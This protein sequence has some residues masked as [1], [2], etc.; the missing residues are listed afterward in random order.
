MEEEA[1]FADGT[2]SVRLRLQASKVVDNKDEML[3]A[4]AKR[5][6]L[7]YQK[8]LF[9]VKKSGII[10]K[11]PE[12]V[13]VPTKCCFSV[14]ADDENEF[15]KEI[16]DQQ[17]SHFNIFKEIFKYFNQA[18]N[19][20]VFGTEDRKRHSAKLEEVTGMKVKLIQINQVIMIGLLA[21][22]IILLLF[23]N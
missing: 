7:I 15:Y 8:W 13:E 17:I 21:T 10:D 18:F 5:R 3:E 11:S 20:L 4:A 14:L 6:F 22:I 1:R 12:A 2:L 9:D 23:R 19:A 16:K